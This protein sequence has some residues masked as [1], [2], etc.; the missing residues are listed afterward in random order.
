MFENIMK[1]H[2]SK[3]AA[4]AQPK[5]RALYNYAFEVQ[6]KYKGCTDAAFKVAFYL[7]NFCK[8]T[9]NHTEM[10]IY[11]TNAQIALHMGLSERT[12]AK[13][14]TFLTLVGYVKRVSKGWSLDGDTQPS[15]YRL[16]DVDT[17]RKIEAANLA[18]GKLRIDREIPECSE[19]TA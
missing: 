17:Q 19:H 10:Y 6:H 4:N 3:L 12:V 7:Q 5:T 1:W 8:T 13:I 9:Y 2:E 18:K 16:N 11:T 15:K 14:I